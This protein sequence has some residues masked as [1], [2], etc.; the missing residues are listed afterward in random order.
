MTARTVGSQTDRNQGEVWT[1]PGDREPVSIRGDTETHRNADVRK[2]RSSQKKHDFLDRHSSKDV[3][4]GCE[5]AAVI[6][7]ARQVSLSSRDKNHPKP[8]GAAPAGSDHPSHPSHSTPT[9]ASAQ[10]VHPDARPPPA[11]QVP[12]TAPAASLQPA[13]LLPSAPRFP[14]QR[15]N[16]TNL[17]GA[18]IKPQLGRSVPKQGNTFGIFPL[19]FRECEKNMK[20]S[21]FTTSI[22]F[23]GGRDIFFYIPLIHPHLTVSYKAKR[24][25]SRTPSRCTG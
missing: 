20:Q 9:P 3:I 15:P 23:G 13:F 11:A 4:P 16:A 2:G 5:H 17:L 18:M 25:S 6:K 21:L 1:R 8:T 22:I 19:P 10:P 14:F 24:S 12:R 7:G